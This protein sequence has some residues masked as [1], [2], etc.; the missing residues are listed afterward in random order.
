MTAL[1]MHTGHQIRLFK[2]QLQALREPP[3]PV[4]ASACL[5]A[6]SSGAEAS[7]FAALGWPMPVNVIDPY[8][9]HMRDLNG[10]PGRQKHDLPLLAALH[11]HGLPSMSA[12]H[13]EAMRD[14]VRFRNTWNEAE[15]ESVLAYCMEDNLAAAALLRAMEAKGL[16]PLDQAL[17]RGRYLFLS[18]GHIEI[19]GIP[20]DV[21]TYERLQ[22][23][24]PRLRHSLIAA[25]DTFGVFVDDHLNHERVTKLITASGLDWPR[26]EN[27][28]LLMDGETWKTMAR[29]RPAL[30]RLRRLLGLLDQLRHTQLSIGSDGRPV[31]DPAATLPHRSESAEHVREHPRQREMV[32]RF[33]NPASWLRH[34]HDRL[35]RPGKR[36]RGRTEWRP[37]DASSL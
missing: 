3:F 30:E 28:R 4:D 8:G 29:Q 2:E 36:Y 24:F 25:E 7:C 37:D 1:E 22:A 31:L 32:A 5:V 19:N 23:A 20:I 12:E 18:G 17:W 14:L 33:G 21:A 11:R 16:V 27:G 10:K 26:N 9:E 6:F 35:L 15:R 13:K 34:R